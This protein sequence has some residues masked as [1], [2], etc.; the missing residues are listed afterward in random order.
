MREPF[1][2]T[3]SL[4]SGAPCRSCSVVG[5]TLTSAPVS[6]RNDLFVLASCKVSEPAMMDAT[7]ARPLRFPHERTG[8]GTWEAVWPKNSWYTHGPFGS[9]VNRS[10][11]SRTLLLLCLLSVNFMAL[12]SGSVTVAASYTLFRVFVCS[13]RE[14]QCPLNLLYGRHLERSHQPSLKLIVRVFVGRF[15]Q[16]I[17][18]SVDRIRVER[19]HD[20]VELGLL[21]GD[22]PHLEVSFCLYEPG[23]AFV[24]PES[25]EFDRQCAYCGFCGFLCHVPRGQTF[26]VI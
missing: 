11:N 14:L 7:D 15:Y 6:M 22:S 20:Q 16:Q 21:T 19:D 4:L 8:N 23:F 3:S 12:V 18:N 13:C 17:Q 5:T 9:W 24:G 25:W 26:G 1:A 10:A 2:V